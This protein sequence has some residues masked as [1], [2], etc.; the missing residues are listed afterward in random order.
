MV[1]AVAAM[2]IVGRAEA[3]AIDHR[4]APRRAVKDERGSAARLAAEAR[5]RCAQ[6]RARPSS[7]SIRIARRHVCTH[8]VRVGEVRAT[9]TPSVDAGPV[10]ARRTRA[11]GGWRRPSS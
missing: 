3:I 11:R 8:G 10:R 2:I 6:T 7:W 1:A 5:P 4:C 9:P